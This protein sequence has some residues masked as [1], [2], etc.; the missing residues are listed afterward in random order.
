MTYRVLQSKLI[1]EGKVFNIRQDQINLPDGRETRID[2]VE[3]EPSVAIVPIDDQ[4]QVWL[5]EQIRFPI[6]GE[7]LELPAGVVEYA[8]SPEE[9]AKREIQE[10]IGMAARKIQL[11]GEFYLAPGYSSEYMYVYL[12][13]DLYPSSLDQDDDEFIQVKKLRFRD[14]VRMAEKGELRDVKTIAGL[15]LARK[16]LAK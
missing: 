8:E 13:Q 11:I 12:A 14:A 10:E 2:V 3:H 7:I 15:T 1:Y 9:T 5:V 6:G 16:L 4:E